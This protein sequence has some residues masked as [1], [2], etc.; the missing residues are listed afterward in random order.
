MTDQG[1]LVGVHPILL[2]VAG[3]WNLVYQF[4]LHTELVGKMPPW[5]ESW[6]NTPSHHRVHHASNLHYRDR[7][8]GGALIVW[9]R[10]FGT[11]TA[12]SEAPLYGIVEPVRSVNPLWIQVHEYV[13]IARDVLRAKRWRDRAGYLFHGPGWVPGS[14]L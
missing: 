13:G 10:L 8:F 1:W 9:D 3:G 6:L 11:F 2:F 5:I 12:E 7:N 4:F 14:S